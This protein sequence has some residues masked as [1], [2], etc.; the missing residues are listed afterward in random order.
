MKTS[1][2][3]IDSYKNICKYFVNN[4][5]AFEK[6]RSFSRDYNSVLEHVSINKGKEYLQLSLENYPN[7][8][9]HF[10][11]ARL[12]DTIGSP[13]TGVYGDAG[14]FSPTTLRYIK[15]RFLIVVNIKH[16]VVYG[17]RI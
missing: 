7:L 2:T 11:R 1:L 12:N 5:D 3:D 10:E 8:K 4:K 14:E 6:F 13:A 15:V 16:L 9:K 17:K